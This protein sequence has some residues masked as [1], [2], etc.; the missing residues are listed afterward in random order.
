MYYFSLNC[1]PYPAQP[2][3]ASIIEL[4]GK[5]VLFI[6]RIAKGE[7][8]PNWKISTT[9]WQWADKIDDDENLNTH[10][11]CTCFIF[12]HIFFNNIL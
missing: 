10:Y 1:A 4:I 6:V 12:Q 8:V 9:T 3:S 7:N 5:N 11:K 2:A